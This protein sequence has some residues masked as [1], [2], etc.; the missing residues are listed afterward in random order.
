MYVDLSFARRASW[1]STVDFKALAAMVGKVA[2]VLPNPVL[3]STYPQTAG[4][5]V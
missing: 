2:M 4:G 3:M 5:Q 1:R